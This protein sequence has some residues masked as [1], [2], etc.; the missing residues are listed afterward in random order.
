[1]RFL[2][3]GG[4][5]FIGTALA[6]T[7]VREGHYVRVLDDLST[8]DPG[9]LLPEVSFTRGDVRDVPKLWTLLQGVQGVFHLAARVS[10]PESIL[11]PREYNDVNVGGTVSVMAAMRDVGVRRVVL[12]SSGTV[13][14]NQPHQPVNE[15]ARPNPL[16]PYAVSK[17][18]AE[19][20]VFTLGALYNIETVALRIF[21][22]YGP[23]QL[24]PPSHPP[25]VPQFLKQAIGGGSVVVFGDGKQTRDFAYIDDV[26]RA[27][28][29]A[30]TSPDVN[31]Q[32]INVGSGKETSINE[33]VRL[34]GRVVGRTP[35]VIYNEAQG[36][37][38]SRLVADLR[39]AASLL[40][41]VPEVELEE[42]LHL[43]LTQD[44]QFHAESTKPRTPTRR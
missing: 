32:I 19:H 23:G 9:Q 3:T 13:Y 26:V 43:L 22:A 4:A 7:L 10:V 16:A 40:G 34:I 2:I 29:S 28:I 21:N 36:G 38:V 17:I 25:V 24:I 11:Y 8:G 37:G 15:D 30:M 14:G 42:G 6:N 39:K 12:A 44:P 31:R 1:M 35:Q 27:L 18:A 41:F 33:L 5:G 20:Y